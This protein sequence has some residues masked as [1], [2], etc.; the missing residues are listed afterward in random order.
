[1][2]I[3]CSLTDTDVVLSLQSSNMEG[4]RVVWNKRGNTSGGASSGSGGTKRG[5]GARTPITHDPITPD[6][7]APALCTTCHGARQ[8]GKPNVEAD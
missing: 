3:W 8:I 1:M 4:D 7:L 5:G 2:V 6:K